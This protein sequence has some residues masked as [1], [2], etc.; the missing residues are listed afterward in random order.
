MSACIDTRKTALKRSKPFLT[1]SPGIT[2]CTVA[3]INNDEEER[4]RRH[5]DAHMRTNAMSPG[6]GLGYVLG[7]CSLNIVK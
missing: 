5:L 2:P 6:V 1:A 3:F 4:R 7:A